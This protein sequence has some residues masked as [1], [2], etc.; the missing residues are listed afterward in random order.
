[1]KLIA[2]VL[3]VLF[4]DLSYGQIEKAYLDKTGQFTSNFKKVDSYVL[5]TKLDQ[6]SAYLARQY[7]RSNLIIL[8]GTYKD[9]LLK[10]P[11]GKFIYYHKSNV[12]K[13]QLAKLKVKLDTD[14]YVQA[15]GCFINGNKTGIWI[16]YSAKN[17][18]AAKLFYENNKLNG[19][20]IIY[21][22]NG[23]RI[24]QQMVNDSLDGK[25]NIFDQNGM[26]LSEAVYSHNKQITFIK[27]FYSSHP[28]E[29]E[30]A[31]LEKKLKKFRGDLFNSTPVIKFIIEKDGSVQHVELI[32]GINPSLDKA[33]LETVKNLPSYYPATYD[34]LPVEQVVTKELMLY[35]YFNYYGNGNIP[36]YPRYTQPK[37]VVYRFQVGNGLIMTQTQTNY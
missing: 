23:N 29:D 24:E 1:M 12:S 18:I 33:I 37:T 20:C 16:I 21:Q 27:H 15:K 13:K 36:L 30:Q 22:D 26:L 31:Y 6:D 14:N 5:I 17:E 2:L 32:K 10:V 28:R 7:D 19:Q 11:N 8:R 3:F 25:W 35:R 34:F 9:H 4:A